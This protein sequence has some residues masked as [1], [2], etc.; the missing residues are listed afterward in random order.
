MAIAAVYYMYVSHV[1]NIPYTGR[2]CRAG[3]FGIKRVPN[4]KHETQSSYGTLLFILKHCSI[5]QQNIQRACNQYKRWKKSFK[6]RCL[7]SALH[8]L[9]P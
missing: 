7:I 8:I 5:K 6:G 2:K 4:K 1:R 3:I 9:S